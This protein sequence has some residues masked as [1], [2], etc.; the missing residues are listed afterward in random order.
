MESAQFPFPSCELLTYVCV[1]YSM[2][3]T[4]QITWREKSLGPFRLLS[5]KTIS[6]NLETKIFPCLLNKRADDENPSI[7]FLEESKPPEKKGK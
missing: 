2:L 1:N 7:L 6:E 4:M 3:K 5:R